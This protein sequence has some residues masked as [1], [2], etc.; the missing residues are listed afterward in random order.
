MQL[1]LSYWYWYTGDIILQQKL[2]RRRNACSGLSCVLSQA[3][4]LALNSGLDFSSSYAGLHRAVLLPRESA[5]RRV[6]MQ[7]AG[8]PSSADKQW[9]QERVESSEAEFIQYICGCGHETVLAGQKLP[10]SALALPWPPHWLSYR[11][12]KGL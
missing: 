10:V 1:I 2:D 6:P 11:Q 7:R 9:H 5:E 3:D 4:H 12:G 8:G